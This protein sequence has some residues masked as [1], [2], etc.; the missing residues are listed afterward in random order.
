MFLSVCLKPSH[1]TIV[2][3]IKLRNDVCPALLRSAIS[4]SL[5]CCCVGHFLGQ[6]SHL[7]KINSPAASRP[8]TGVAPSHVSEDLFLQVPPLCCRSSPGQREHSHQQ[9]H[10]TQAIHTDTHTHTHVCMYAHI[11]YMDTHTYTH[12]VY[13]VGKISILTPADFASLATC[14]EMCDL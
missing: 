5:Q 10:N 3:K 2:L 8:P 6:F 9:G 14:K 7:G 1:C 11:L 12:I 13:T 4:H